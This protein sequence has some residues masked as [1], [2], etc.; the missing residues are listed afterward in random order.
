V[1]PKERVSASGKTI[2][3][4]EVPLRADGKFDCA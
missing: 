2:R 1:T 4:L 3:Y